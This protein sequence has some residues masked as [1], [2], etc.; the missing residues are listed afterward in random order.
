[1]AGDI[2]RSRVVLGRETCPEWGTL[3]PK[4]VRNGADLNLL[5][6]IGGHCADM[7]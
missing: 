7:L 6:D 3:P 5:G 4:S 1:M 2:F